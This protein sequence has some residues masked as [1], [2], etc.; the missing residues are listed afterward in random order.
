MAEWAFYIE[1]GPIGQ[2]VKEAAF[3]AGN[4]RRALPDNQGLR[5]TQTEALKNG[6]AACG[7][8]P[9]P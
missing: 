6:G 4:I 2:Q 3:H 5:M 1:P 9:L 8:S 7:V